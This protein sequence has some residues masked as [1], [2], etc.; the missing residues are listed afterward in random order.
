[1]WT[2][3]GPNQRWCPVCQQHY[4]AGQASPVRVGNVTLADDCEYE[5]RCT[6]CGAKLEGAKV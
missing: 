6:A 5:A 1:M 2:N 4:T 3:P